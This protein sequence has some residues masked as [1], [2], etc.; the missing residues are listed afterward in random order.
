MGIYWQT[1]FKNKEKSVL[2]ASIDKII[3]P[4]DINRGYVLKEELLQYYGDLINQQDLTEDALL[5]EYESCTLSGEN[6]LMKTRQL[7]IQ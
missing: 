2:L 4:N 6:S 7:K 3:D 1:Y 5:I